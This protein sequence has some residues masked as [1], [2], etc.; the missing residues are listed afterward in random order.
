G[1][2]RTDGHYNEQR[3]IQSIHQTAAQLVTDIDHRIA[4]LVQAS[5]T[6]HDVALT[7]KKDEH[8][9]QHLRSALLANA[10]INGIGPK[11]RDRLVYSGFRTAADINST[12]LSVR[13]IGL[14]RGNDL[15]GW[16][17]AL[18]QTAR[19][20]EPKQL[21]IEEASIIR[22]HYEQQKTSLWAQRDRELQG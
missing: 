4:G 3:E 21:S 6:E 14:R 11:L 2:L 12:V 1:V 17:R 22:V 7:R 8:L 19:M 16:R 20:T 15:L 9:E 5:R 13:D 10:T 18:E